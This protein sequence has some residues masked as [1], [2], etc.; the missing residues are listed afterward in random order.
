MKINQPDAA[1]KSVFLALSEERPKILNFIRKRVRNTQETEDIYQE[2]VTRLTRQISNNEQLENPIGY[3]YRVVINLI[4]DSMRRGNAYTMEVL[5]DDITSQDPQPEERVDNQQRLAMFIKLLNRLPVTTRNIIV[6]RKLYGKSN[7]EIAEQM[8][9]SVKAVEKKL[10]RALKM[11][12][13]NM[14]QHF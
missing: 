9:I 8:D 7:I 12:E 1:N 6:M 14:A 13:Q 3:L 10:N 11:I 2:A 4:N 5:S